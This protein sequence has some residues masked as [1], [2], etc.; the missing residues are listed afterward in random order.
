MFKIVVVESPIFCEHFLQ[1]FENRNFK[2]QKIV[3]NYDGN[4]WYICEQI[5]CYQLIK[6]LLTTFQHPYAHSFPVHL[7]RYSLLIRYES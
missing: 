7:I 1:L 6:D 3:N 5:N 2:H 4:S